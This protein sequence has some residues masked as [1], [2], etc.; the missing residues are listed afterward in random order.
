MTYSWQL[1]ILGIGLLLVVVLVVV[2]LLAQFGVQL[3]YE[4]VKPIL[5]ADQQSVS[6]LGSTSKTEYKLIFGGDVMLARRVGM[7]IA[8]WNS[9]PF[10]HVTKTLQGADLAIV[11]LECVVSSLGSARLGKPYTFR[12]DPATLPLLTAAGIDMVSVANNHSGDFGTDAFSDMLK[13][14]TAQGLIYFGGGENGTEAYAPRYVTLG[15]L[16]LAVLGFSN[17]ETPYFTATAN[18]PG[19]AWFKDDLVT[20]AIKQAKS[21]ADL[22]I[23]MPHWGTEYTEVV[24]AEQVRLAKLMINAGADLIVGSHPHHL[25]ALTTYKGKYIAYSLGNFVFDGPGPNPA[26]SEAGMLQV[27]VTQ[28]NEKWGVKSA[29]LI[30]TQIDAWGTVSLR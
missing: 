2:W 23:V 20:K 16:K 17:I 3:R 19:L 7:A 29:Q 11:N 21:K 18:T 27:V 26:W 15:D 30:P 6:V 22:V 13:R 28:Q 24:N 9:N 12:A 10:V 14:L 5:A 25:Q 8:N 4:I 1:K